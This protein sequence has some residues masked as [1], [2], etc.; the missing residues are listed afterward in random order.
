VFLR[1]HLII[2]LFLEKRTS[3]I[4]FAVRFFETH[5][6]EVALQ[7]ILQLAHDKL[8]PAVPTLPAHP[9]PVGPN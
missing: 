3:K 6:K 8:I 4:A 1:S 9:T 5:N 2:L 7:C